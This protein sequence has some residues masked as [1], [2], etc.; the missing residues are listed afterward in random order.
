MAGKSRLET[1]QAVNSQPGQPGLY[2]CTESSVLSKFFSG[3]SW[4]F[5]A[6]ALSLCV[7]APVDTVIVAHVLNKLIPQFRWTSCDQM[8]ALAW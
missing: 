7:S 8:T 1:G 2:L 6:R 3:P 4:P 5:R